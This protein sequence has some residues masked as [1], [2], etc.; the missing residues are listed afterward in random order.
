MSP[1]LPTTP[2]TSARPLAEAA[3]PARLPARVVSESGTAPSPDCVHHPSWKGPLGAVGGVESDDSMNDT[4]RGRW[5]AAAVAVL[6][7]ALAGCAA[8]PAA[9]PAAP[10]EQVPVTDVRGTDGR[11][12]VTLT[13]AE[14]QVPYDGGTRW[15]MTYNGTTPGPTLRVHPGDTL[16]ITLV[17]DLAEPTSLHTHGLHVS[18]EQDDP[19]VMVEPG[20]S[21]TFTYD[22]PK[23]QQPGT[24][25]YHPHVHQM[26]A[27]QVAAGL[28]G[29]IIVEGADDTTLADVSTDR[30]LV[31][32]DPPITTANPDEGQSSGG[33][34]MGHDGSMMGDSGTD[35]MTAMMGR[36][37]PRLLT[38][39]QDGVTLTD[40]AGKLERVHVVNATASTSLRLAYD[41]AQMLRL[42]SPGGRLAAPQQAS[43][44]ELAPGERTE[45]VLVP[46]A[47]G[48]T[49]TAQRL[50]NEGRGGPTGEP[51][52]VA[53][54]EPGA[55]ADTS[56]LPASFH[57]DDRDLFAPDVKVARTRAITLDGHMDPTIDGKPF[58]ADTVNFT[59]KEG[60]VEE[61]VIKNNTPMVHP[62]HLHT[63]P[64]Q[65]EGQAGWQDVV[66]V[67]AY[68]EKVIRV[69]FDDFTGTT[70]IHCHI[71]DHEDTGMMA[72]IKVVP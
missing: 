26:T 19:F 16:S 27:Q 24:Y 38:N 36:T 44:V 56:V 46:G 39:G 63:W 59:A 60:T 6:L 41:G 40:P 4:R 70:V 34:M 3:I 54:V 23:D 64:F 58:D 37:G 55:G 14:T 72:V 10:Q 71:L 18:P 8:Q 53:R 66:S 12:A 21:R 50:A 17:N 69:P 52:V 42:A 25:W 43:A 48:G 20:R 49:L 5:A 65:T 68:G 61:W 7:L 35:M 11:V 29:A 1:N 28:S 51:E 31:V 15:A 9:A 13:A 2:D 57:S 62:I 30:V 45:L 47:D 67:P 33:S 32:N 22:I